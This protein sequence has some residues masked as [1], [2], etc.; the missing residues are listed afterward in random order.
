MSPSDKHQRART[1]IA[2]F[3]LTVACT[4]REPVTPS[5]TMPPA[6]ISNDDEDDFSEA[7]GPSWG[8]QVSKKLEI[9]QMTH[10]EQAEN[11][12]AAQ[13]LFRHA[14]MLVSEGRAAEAITFYEQAYQ[15]VPGKHN[16][17]HKIGITAWTIG[18]CEKA[19]IYLSHYLEWGDRKWVDRLTEA[20]QVLDDIRVRGCTSQ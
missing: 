11:M 1:A 20:R 10:E 3:T 9:R 13:D 19:E 6:R 12:E 7:I 5:T 18:D 4:H 2:S 17:A 16:L 8:G 14:E 15:L